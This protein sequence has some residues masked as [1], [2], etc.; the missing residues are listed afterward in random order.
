MTKQVVELDILIK[1]QSTRISEIEAL[2]IYMIMPQRLEHQSRL[3]RGKM[4]K[5]RRQSLWLAVAKSAI[6]D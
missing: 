6:A 4:N 1:C 2:K 3:R 5:T